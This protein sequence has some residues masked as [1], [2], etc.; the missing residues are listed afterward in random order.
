MKTSSKTLERKTALDNEV[1]ALLSQ[2]AEDKILSEGEITEGLGHIV[3]I[4][5]LERLQDARKVKLTLGT[6]NAYLCQLL[7]TKTL[8]RATIDYLAAQVRGVIEPKGGEVLIRR[9][10]N[11]IAW[12][13]REERGYVSVGCYSTVSF[14]L[15]ISAWVYPYEVPKRFQMPR[16]RGNGQRD[17][18]LSFHFS[19]VHLITGSDLVRFVRDRYRHHCQSDLI[20]RWPLFFASGRWGVDYAWTVL[21]HTEQRKYEHNK[22]GG[23]QNPFSDCP[24][25]TPPS[26]I[27]A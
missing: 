22:P 10:L 14:R 27:P 24:L 23:H 25:C 1:L 26:A 19:E 15:R 5:C 8:S 11:L 17:T 2:G 7:S 13:L 21:G 20:Y 12:K 16:P 4:C 18:E 3:S 6:N 9:K